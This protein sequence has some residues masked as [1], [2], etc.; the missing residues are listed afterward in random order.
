MRILR[1]YQTIFVM[2]AVTGVARAQQVA[3][4]D[5]LGPPALLAPTQREEQP[6]VP[7]SCSRMGRGYADGVTLGEDKTPR[8]IKVDL[9]KMSRTKLALGSEI[10]ATAKLQNAGEKS[11]QIPW[12]TDFR[13]TMDGQNPDNR[14]WE[15]GEFRMSV[16]DR[17]NPAYYDQLVTT[18]QPLYA[19]KFIAGS[20]LTLKPGEWITARITFKI[21]VQ[22]PK[23]EKLS[24]GAAELA[25][26]WFQ[27][28][29]TRSAKDCGVTLGYF[30]YDHPFKSLNRRVIAKVEIAPRKVVPRLVE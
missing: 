27:T 3:S 5:L 19:S 15:F 23:F 18:S 17:Q 2:I 25:M 13:T 1:A 10:V 16:R 30:P 21:A 14:L 6:E 9:L 12:S 28:V 8:T 26:E 24:V 4:K 7:K 11:I 20:Y 22:N 29:R